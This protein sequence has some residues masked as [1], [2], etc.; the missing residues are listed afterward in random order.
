[1]TEPFSEQDKPEK[2]READESEQHENEDRP[3]IFSEP[4]V[5]EQ[6]REGTNPAEQQSNQKE[7]TSGVCQDREKPPVF[8]SKKTKVLT[9]IVAVFILL[10]FG[11][12]YTINKMM[13]S[14][15]AVA[16]R[17]MDAVEEK[18]DSK[19]RSFI[20]DGQLEM[21]VTKADVKTFLE[22]LDD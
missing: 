15:E 4:I 9:L 10:L 17:F 7:R 11:S 21:D 6:E 2:W 12:Y 3:E 1:D 18:D 16:E 5:P 22:F 8:K 14:P 13:M 19:L 20:N